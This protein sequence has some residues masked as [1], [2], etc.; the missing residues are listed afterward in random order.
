[1][2]VCAMRNITIC[3][4]FC[5]LMVLLPLTNI[6][7]GLEQK[8]EGVAPFKNWTILEGVVT[9]PK[10]VRINGFRYLE[11]NAF[12]VHYRTHTTGE[13]RAGLFHSFEKIVLPEFHYGYVGLHLVLAKWDVCLIP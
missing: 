10:H 3:L 12:L 2:G 4:L 6:G 5:L 9:R 8:P 11:F 7:L 1:M 13:I